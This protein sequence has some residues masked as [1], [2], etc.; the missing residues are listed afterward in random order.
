MSYGSRWFHVSPVPGKVSPGFLG[1]GNPGE[2][3]PLIVGTSGPVYDPGR[4]WLSTLIAVGSLSACNPV[5][6]VMEAPQF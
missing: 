3:Y 4:Q 2:L 6:L 5:A 1:E